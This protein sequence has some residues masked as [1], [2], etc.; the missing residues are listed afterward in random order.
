MAVSAV[1]RPAREKPKKSQVNARIDS[2]L[3][4][5]GDEGLA[6]AG[7][8]PT[9]AVHA[10]WELAA[11]NRE[12]PGAISA[13][14]F[15][16][17]RD[18]EKAALAE[19]RERRRALIEEAPAIIERAYRERGLPWPPASSGLSFDELKEAAYRQA[20]PGLFGGAA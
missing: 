17:E 6:A 14:L 11:R 1:T 15:P 18:R 5:M 4:K 16:E 19:E 12:N 20:H 8:T 9:Q 7:L 2:D 3:K 13:A 10:L